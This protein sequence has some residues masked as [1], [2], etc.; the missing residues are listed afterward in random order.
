MSGVPDL[1]LVA[2]LNAFMRSVYVLW[3]WDQLLALKEGSHVEY[4]G[5]KENFLTFAV[6]LLEDA[7]DEAP[8]YLRVYVHVC[9]LRLGKGLG[10]VYQPL[11]NSFLVY[12]D[13]KIDAEE[14]VR[15]AY[16]WQTD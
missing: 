3:S 16:G 8:P 1:E 6:D 9:D 4:R 12:R 13:G 7:R 10:S 15:F 11:C 14:L 2:Q 5:N